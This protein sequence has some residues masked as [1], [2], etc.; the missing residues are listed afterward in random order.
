MTTDRGLALGDGLFETIRVVAGVAP[1]EGL[2]WQRLAA[3]A[4]RLGLVCEHS[5]WQQGLTSLLDQH[6]HQDGIAKLIFTAG[7]GGRG[8]GRPAAPEPCWHWSWNPYH[9]RPDHL[10]RDGLELVLADIRLADQ[11]ALAGMKHLNRLEQVLARA[12]LPA[13]ADELL[14][15]D[16]AGRPQCL[17]CMNIYARSGNRLWTPPVS[18]CGVAG[19]CRRLLLK[20][21]ITDTGLALDHAPHT[22]ALLAQADEVFASNAIAGILPVRKLG[23][24]TWPVGNSS[25]YFQQCYRQALGL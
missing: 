6:P 24:L 14:V 2:H 16:A 10:Y 20:D 15:C 17:S 21:W 1:L 19:V 13:H 5:D 12:Q 9:S 8:Y 18:R 4:Q 7:S 25:R 22:L 23:L 3:G 11:P